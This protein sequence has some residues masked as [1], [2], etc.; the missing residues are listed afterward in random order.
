MLDIIKNKFIDLEDLAE[1]D[2]ITIIL[3][4]LLYKDET[5][6]MNAIEILSLHF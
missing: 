4:L 3:D 2:Y 6:V 1:R 5:L